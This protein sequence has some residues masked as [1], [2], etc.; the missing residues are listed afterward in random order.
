[1]KELGDYYARL[2]SW[3]TKGGFKDELG[4]FHKSDHHYSLPYWEIFNEIDF[5]HAMTPEQYTE[6]YDAVAEAIHKVSPATKFVGLALAM[7]SLNPKYFDY[8]LDHKNHKP[9]IPLD[10][11]SYHFYASPSAEETIENWQ[12]TFFDQADGFLKAV[13]YIEATRKR[14]SPETRTTLDEIGSDPGQR[15]RPGRSRACGSADP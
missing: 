3:Y 13:R 14:L 15:Q 4:K 7:P 1:M 8:F 12:Y 9:G 2:L 5:E 11:I 6:R 10:M